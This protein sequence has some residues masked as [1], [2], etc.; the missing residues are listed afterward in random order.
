MEKCIGK[1]YMKLEKGVRTALA[2]FTNIS[3]IVLFKNHEF[4]CLNKKQE[5]F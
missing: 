4:L 1:L 5:R 3:R 2:L